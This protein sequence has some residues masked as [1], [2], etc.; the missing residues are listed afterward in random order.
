VVQRKRSLVDFVNLTSA[1]AARLLGL[2][3]KKGAI[4]AGSDADLVLIDPVKRG[5]LSMQDLHETDYSPWEGWEVAGWPV[6]TI[7]RGRVV[8][9]HGRFLGDPRYGRLVARKVSDAVLAGG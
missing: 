7:L 9:D 6:M 1:N 2:Y 3:P 4:A 5:P 8:V